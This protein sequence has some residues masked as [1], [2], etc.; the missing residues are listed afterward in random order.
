MNRAELIEARATQLVSRFGDYVQTYDDRVPF[1]GEQLISHRE[2]IMLRRQAANVRAA[3]EDAEFI[4][5]LRRTLQAWG[6]GRRASRLVPE[7]EFAVALKAALP[8]IEPL[9]PMRIDAADLPDDIAE[10]LWLLINSLGVVENRAKLVAG[11]KT[12][13]HLV[14][15]LVPPM[16]REWTGLFF[17]FH[18]PEWQ[19]QGS[20]RRIFH[21]AFNQFLTVARQVQPQQ[22]VTNTG[23]RTSRTKI[24]DNA[25][26]GFCKTDL[27]G[28]PLPVE[29]APNQVTFDVNDYPPPKGE[30]ISML[31]ADHPY[32]P[33][34]RRLLEAAGQARIAQGFAPISNAPVALDVVL[35]SP[36]GQNRADATNYLGG[37]AD[38]LENKAH[39]GSLDY[40]GDLAT[41]CLYSNDR[42]IKEVTYREVAAAEASYTVTVRE[43]SNGH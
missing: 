1:T 31:R 32:A 6:I 41:V 12:L 43:I 10:R 30:A 19:D 27:G 3:V 33:R 42:Q 2:T 15:D 29:D 5:S 28:Q 23:W 21:I 4:A 40:L 39:R 38:V 26:I 9:E 8:I 36:A 35:Y 11:T 7:V 34:V 18:L 20:Q 16:D 13:H 17:Q 37:I 22:Y 25:L 14:P 24:L